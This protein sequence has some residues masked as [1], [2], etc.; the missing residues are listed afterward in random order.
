MTDS[1][2]FTTKCGKKID[3][4]AIPQSGLH[5][6]TRD[7]LLHVARIAMLAHDIKLLKIRWEL[8]ESQTTK[9][10]LIGIIGRCNHWGTKA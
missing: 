10:Q 8:L 4:N 6:Y 9:Q 7:D 5:S 2:L 1:P 3:V